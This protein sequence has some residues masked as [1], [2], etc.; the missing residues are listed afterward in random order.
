MEIWQNVSLSPR[1]IE[2][3]PKGNKES[4]GPANLTTDYSSRQQ[5]ERLGPFMTVGARDFVGRKFFKEFRFVLDDTCLQVQT[6]VFRMMSHRQV[7]SRDGTVTVLQLSLLSYLH[8]SSA[9][10]WPVYKRCVI[11]SSCSMRWN[12]ITSVIVPQGLCKW[13]VSVGGTVEY[14]INWRGYKNR[15]GFLYW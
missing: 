12:R 10:Q 4:P 8:R 11:A 9:Q 13:D 15:E 6:A 14:F 3:L 5:R 2:K 7:S 1:V